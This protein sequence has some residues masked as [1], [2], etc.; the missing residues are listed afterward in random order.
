[1]TFA[2]LAEWA[3]GWTGVTLHDKP[4]PE[5]EPAYADE[6]REPVGL[7]ARL[8]VEQREYVLNYKGS[9]LLSDSKGRV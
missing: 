4:L 7:F 8:T 6:P 9:D 1:M 2:K 3:V 5:P